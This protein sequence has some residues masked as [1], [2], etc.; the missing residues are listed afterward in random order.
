MNRNLDYDHL[1]G[2]I[3]T[4]KELVLPGEKRLKLK[5]GGKAWRKRE[6]ERA[7]AR[8]KIVERSLNRA[9]TQ[10][11][12]YKRNK[13]KLN[14]DRAMRNRQPEYVYYKAKKRAE[15]LDIDW[16]FDLESWAKVWQD[17]PPLVDPVT[18]F[19]VP[20]WSLKGGNAS[21]DAQMVRLDTNKGWSP[22]N[23]AIAYKGTVLQTG[24]HNDEY[25]D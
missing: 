8:D 12:Y 18:G 10:S 25:Q 17:A 5:K 16:D 19:M 20:A 4:E 1:Y 13:E 14:R 11:K 21:R 15:G 2:L 9:K 23:C 6:R 7:A 22:E 24:E 3:K